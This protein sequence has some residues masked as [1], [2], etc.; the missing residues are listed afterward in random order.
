M[1]KSGAG[2]GRDLEQ[3]L[4]DSTATWK[5]SGAQDSQISNEGVSLLKGS[6]NTYRKRECCCAWLIQKFN[7]LYSRGDREALVEISETES[8]SQKG[9]ASLI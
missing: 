8:S 7:S 6:E 2:V 1:K 9:P 3:Y 4:E 5:K